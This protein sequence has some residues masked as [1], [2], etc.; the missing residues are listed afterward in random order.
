MTRARQSTVSLAGMR[1][2]VPL[3]ENLAFVPSKTLFTHHQ[4]FV[5]TIFIRK[6]Y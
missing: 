5:E 4:I 1:N 2:R 6:E 3:I